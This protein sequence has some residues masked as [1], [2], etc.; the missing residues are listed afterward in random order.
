MLEQNHDFNAFLTTCEKCN[1]TIANF[2]LNNNRVN[3]NGD[4]KI[5]RK[6]FTEGMKQEI[7]EHY[8][9]TENSAEKAKAFSLNVST[10]RSI[11]KSTMRDVKLSDKCYHS[12]ASRPLRM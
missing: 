9:L 11:F 7:W 5:P 1:R 3:S 4:I 10:M 8:L 12:G 6:R 2:Y